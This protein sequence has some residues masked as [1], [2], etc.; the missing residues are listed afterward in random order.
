MSVLLP[1]R[2]AVA[3]DWPRAVED[4]EALSAYGMA[5]PAIRFSRRRCR[6]GAQGPVA[7]SRG[8][9]GMVASAPRVDMGPVLPATA[10]RKCR[11]ATSH[12]ELFPFAPLYRVWVMRDAAS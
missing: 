12:D 9:T 7:E 11:T 3:A 5:L 2:L 4:K 1:E 10:C 6:P 8:E